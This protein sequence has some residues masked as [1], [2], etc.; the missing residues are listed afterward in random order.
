MQSSSLICTP[1]HDRQ[2]MISKTKQIYLF[3][4]KVENKNT[5]Y[6]VSK[7]YNK[8]IKLW[9]STCAQAAITFMIRN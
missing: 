5:K 8:N 4:F 6:L 7:E 9:I 3:P 1:Y 2:P